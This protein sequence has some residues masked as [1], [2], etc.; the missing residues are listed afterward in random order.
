MNNSQDILWL[1]YVLYY[2]KWLSEEEHRVKVSVISNTMSTDNVKTKFHMERV[3]GS[4]ESNNNFNLVFFFLI[5]LSAT[6]SLT[7]VI[8]NTNKLIGTF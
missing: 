5:G 1:V 8:N 3:G 2:L 6:V 7:Q 4:D